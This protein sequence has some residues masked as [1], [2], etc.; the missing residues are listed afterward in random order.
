MD[1][2]A[3]AEC[4]LK[5]QESQYL[6]VEIFA[7]QELSAWRGKCETYCP[8]IN[9]PNLWLK[10]K[11]LLMQAHENLTSRATRIACPA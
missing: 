5:G 2:E 9:R 7:L 10:N 3:I 11:C 4:L 6:R 1:E 8:G